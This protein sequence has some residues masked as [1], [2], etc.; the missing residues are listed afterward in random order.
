MC[1]LFLLIL[2]Q[3]EKNNKNDYLIGVILGL[4][5]LTKQNIGIF[6]C[7]PTLFTKD[8]KKIIK[9]I[10]G[11]LIPNLFLII[12]LL[13]HNCLY[14]FIDYTFLG[15]REFASQ[16][17]VMYPSTTIIL[18]LSI[19]YLIYKY[20]KTKDKTCLYL[21]CFF[22]LSF[23]IVDPYHVII[24]FAPTLA[25]F[26]NQ[27]N[28]QKFIIKIAFASFILGIFMVNY[29][30]FHNQNYT[31]PNNTT[32]YKYRKI[33]DDTASGIN[34][35]S[36]YLNNNK[37]GYTYIIDSNAYL[38]KLNAG[39][40]INK[41][42]LLYNGNMGASGDTRVI[43]ELDE[44]CQINECTF[45]INKDSINKVGYSQYNE[46]IHYYIIDNYQE[47][48]MILGYSLYQNK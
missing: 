4:T 2:I 13:Y 16:N 5:F 31:Y 3:L 25:Y 41:Y 19:I 43:D 39:I 35:I 32:M 36:D 27:F 20:I 30:Q 15:M 48:G 9:R 24:P 37:N 46:K 28:L 22:G 29:M 45:L 14:E 11:F 21:L 8:I 7:I 38:I 1:L 17:N 18:I 10:I 26:L 6:L 33:N 44:I 47:R 12:Y 23:P 42:D 34:T 40:K